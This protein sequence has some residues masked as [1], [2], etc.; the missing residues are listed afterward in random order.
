MSTAENWSRRKL[1]YEFSDPNLL[2]LALTH[3]SHSSANNERLEF[4]GDAL[5]GA[6]IASALFRQEVSVDEGMLSRLRASLVRRET[7]AEI[8]GETGL[9]DMLRLGSGE[10]RSGG[11]Q[12]QSILADSLEAVFGAIYLDGGFTAVRRVILGLYSAR[13]ADLPRSNALKD[14]KT[15][16]QESLQGQGIDVPDYIVLSEE[17]PPHNRM[18]AVACRIPS[19]EIETR[20]VASS[21]RR[22]EQ[23]AAAKAADLLP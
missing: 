15:L 10:A 11:H 6:V 1:G 23:I 20:G 2:E 12:R 9:G 17:G 18:F 5:L 3:K 22:A 4:L 7:L 16:L 19:L 14:P 21:R 8:A 13:L